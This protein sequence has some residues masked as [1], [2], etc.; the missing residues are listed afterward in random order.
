VYVEGGVRY[1]RSARNRRASFEAENGSVT[2]TRYRAADSMWAVASR[3][4]TVGDFR[5]VDAGGDGDDRRVRYVATG[6]AVPNATDVRGSLT[7]DGDGV[8]REARLRY[9]RAGERKRFEYA[10]S[11][12]SGDVAAP[13]WLPAARADASLDPRSGAAA[14]AASTETARQVEPRRGGPTG[15]PPEEVGD[16]PAS[17]ARAR[18]RPVGRHRRVYGLRRERR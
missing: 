11:P 16:E 13:P 12:R 9:V 17:G 14:E 6:V 10:V 5:A 15:R 3:I 2:E 7:V 18:L 1:V 8:V 4:L